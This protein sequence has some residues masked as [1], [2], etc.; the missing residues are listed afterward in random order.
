MAVLP[1]SVTRQ[2]PSEGSGF[3]RIRVLWVAGQQKK[4]YTPLVGRLGH[5]R[6]AETPAATKF[7][8][9]RQRFVGVD[10][11]TSAQFKLLAGDGSVEVGAAG[12]VNHR[13]RGEDRAIE[14]GSARPGD[15]AAA[16]SQ[17]Q[18][19]RMLV[20]VDDAAAGVLTSPLT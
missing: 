12:D 13:I 6:P 16:G 11:A 8:E 9:R 10:L 19:G 4:A 5:A 17:Q 1:K 2:R 20:G 14:G 18:V 15:L 3:L 7:L